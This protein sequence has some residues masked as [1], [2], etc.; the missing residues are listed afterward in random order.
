MKTLSEDYRKN[1][2]KWLRHVSRHLQQNSLQPLL[3][4]LAKRRKELLKEYRTSSRAAEFSEEARHRRRQA[5]VRLQV[6]A[7]AYRLLCAYR[8][9]LLVQ[10]FVCRPEALALHLLSFATQTHKSLLLGSQTLKGV[11]FRGFRPTEEQR[12]EALE[13]L[14]SAKKLFGKNGLPAQVEPAESAEEAARKARNARRR[15]ILR[16]ILAAGILTPKEYE[17]LEQLH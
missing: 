1:I 15:L 12:L 16:K 13:L 6:V 3:E 11:S 9:Q 10:G 14:Q 17:L 7:P 5:H 4:H 8:Q 2:Q